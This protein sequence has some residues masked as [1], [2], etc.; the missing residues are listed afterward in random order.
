MPLNTPRLASGIFIRAPDV[1][2]GVLICFLVNPQPPTQPQPSA[3]YKNSA[4]AHAS[5]SNPVQP[6]NYHPTD[7]G[8]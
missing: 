8:Q 1:L 6:S 5:E 2:S 3:N 4:Q 7:C